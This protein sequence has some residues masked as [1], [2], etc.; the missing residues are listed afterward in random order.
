MNHI[1]Q[2]FGY[3]MHTQRVPIQLITP[4]KN[5]LDDTLHKRYI[6]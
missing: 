3:D 4:D 1:R 5:K 6:L 2:K